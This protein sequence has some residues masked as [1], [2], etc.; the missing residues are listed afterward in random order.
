MINRFICGLD[1]AGRGA[2]AGPLVAASVILTKS[3]KIIEKTAQ[4]PLKDSKTISKEKRL[5]IFNSL[6]KHK[7]IINIEIISTRSINNHGIGW[8][9]KE[10]F[11][12]LIK[13]GS[14]NIFVVDGSLKLGKFRDKTKIIKS[15]IRAD[16]TIEP[17]IAAGI[18]AKVI[19]DYIMNN[20]SKIFPVYFWEQNSGY[21]T[22]VHIQTIIKYGLVNYHRQIFTKTALTNFHHKSSFTET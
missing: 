2:L 14:A 18:V 11:R 5:A 17:V 21:G 3:K 9:N 4:S 19:R 20:L 13:K 22:K 15:V 10:I 16:A 12:R 8:A 6:I 7:S 1:E